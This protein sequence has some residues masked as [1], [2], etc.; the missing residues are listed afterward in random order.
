MTHITY[1]SIRSRVALR[2]WS[3]ATGLVVYLTSVNGYAIDMVKTC[4]PA[5]VTFEH[6][7]AKYKGTR[8][9][10]QELM[11][12]I[13]DSSEGAL[14]TRDMLE[15]ARDG[16]RSEYVRIV[17]AV[18][19]AVSANVSSALTGIVVAAAR[20]HDG[21]GYVLADLT[22]RFSPD[23]WAR[24][25]V[26]ALEQYKSDRIVAEGH[27]GGDLVRYTLSTI[28]TNLPISIVHAS[29]SKQARA[30]PVAALYEQRRVTHLS[31]FPELDDQLVT[32]EPLSGDPSPDRLDALVWALTDLML[33]APEPS[34][35]MPIFHGVARTIPGQRDD[36]ETASVRRYRP[37]SPTSRS[38]TPC[39]S[40]ARFF[41]RPIEDQPPIPPP[42][43]SSFRACGLASRYRPPPPSPCR[44]EARWSSARPEF[45]ST[46]LQAVGLPSLPPA[47]KAATPLL[48]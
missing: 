4:A 26:D 37:G 17:V 41:R 2:K 23:G 7:I 25:S 1:G 46:L 6:I 19:P 28:K 45:A 35:A 47:R 36:S 10:R 16:A 32:W 13:L 15:A 43:R 24:V 14:W 33:G 42:R 40:P 27:Q 38:P 18:D 12:D 30:E 44:R 29:R 11:G 34:F 39:H 9:G 31:A 20:G 8:L 5:V 48:R 22:G 21:R 3:R